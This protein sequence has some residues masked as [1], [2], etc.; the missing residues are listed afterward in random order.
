MKILKISLI[1]L[2][3]I[4][5]LGCPPKKDHVPDGPPVPKPGGGPFIPSSNPLQLTISWELPP[6]TYQEDCSLNLVLEVCR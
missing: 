3:C 4:L 6:Y 5:F 2:C 1:I